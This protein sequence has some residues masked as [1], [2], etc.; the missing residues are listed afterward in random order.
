LDNRKISLC[1][2]NYNRVE[3]LIK[4]FSQVIDDDRISEIVISDD[5]SDI[6]LYNQLKGIV[7]AL[8]P[9]HNN[10]IKLYRNEI[11]LDCY[12]NKKQAIS[13]ATN[14]WVIIFDSDNTLDQSYL[15]RLY[16][17]E[18]WQ[19]DTS[20]MPSFAKPLFSYQQYEG[21]IL[22]KENVAQ[23]IDMPFLSTCLNCMNY[24]VNRDEYLRVWQ[25][26]IDPHTADSLLQNY[27]WFAGGNKMLIVPNLHYNHLVHDGSHY[28]N[29]VHLTGNLYAEIEEKIK[30]LK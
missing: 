12:K 8:N 20:Y 22:S 5:C 9:L 6:D 4:S 16:E 15:D 25:D 7:S 18:E 29:Q 10:K 27:N 24:F 2:T 3:L 1:L 30:Q 13:L 26:D 17:I 21:V 28:K 14:D 19:K 11:N 23:Y